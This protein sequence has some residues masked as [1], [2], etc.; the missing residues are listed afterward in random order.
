MKVKDPT[1]TAATIAKMAADPDPKIQDMFRRA[2]AGDKEAVYGLQDVFNKLHFPGVDVSVLREV[3]EKH[4]FDKLLGL[5]EVMRFIDRDETLSKLFRSDI[6]ETFF[7]PNF[8][9]EFAAA[10]G[11]G[12]GENASKEEATA[13]EAVTP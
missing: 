1:Q 4:T 9:A 5:P 8:G 2:Q 13:T 6:K 7:N 11:T 10:A 3:S 12:A